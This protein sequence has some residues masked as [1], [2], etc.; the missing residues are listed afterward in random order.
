MNGARALVLLALALAACDSLPFEPAGPDAAPDPAK[1]GP[2]PV[3][4]RTLV[5]LDP[6][7]LRPDHTPRT[8][9]TEVWYPAAEEARGKPGAR[10]E[11]AAL[12][13]EAQRAQLAGRALPV[14]QTGAVRDATP[15][16][17]HGPY[18]LVVFSHAHTGVRWQSPYYTVQLASHGYVVAAPDHEG[19]TFAD[20][21]RDTL[22]PLLAGFST[23][24]PDVT[25]V[26]DA[27]AF[28]PE[29]DPLAG[30]AVTDRVGV[31]G[32]SYGGMTSL[33]VAAL[34]ARVAAIVP[35]APPSAELAWL[36]Q[37][38]PFA[39][40]IPVLLEVAH[41]DL[42]LPWEEHAAPTW[43]LLHKPRW[44]VDITHGGH[45]TFSDLCAF[46]LA[47]LV[48]A[49]DLQNLDVLPGVDAAGVYSDGC[50]P[51]APPASQTQPIIDHFAIAFFNGVLRESP[52]SLALLT[53][54]AADALA[55]GVAEVIA[56]P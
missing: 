51:G 18:P 3:G 53:Q 49:L 45:L 27:I 29:S 4:V 25:R 43:A 28:L 47:S 32:H 7:R 34:D 12:L 56:D 16:L 9:V 48:L 36:D 22:A 24:P 19:G 42:T 41:G 39:L 11:L 21:L 6:E 37:P 15:D 5:V 1:P 44:R 40:S 46:D 31:T 20:A 26:I 35:Q 23:R 33:R 17:D 50:G 38:P 2:F 30:L 55:P 14:L 13:T 10:Y 8:L 52:G 54:A